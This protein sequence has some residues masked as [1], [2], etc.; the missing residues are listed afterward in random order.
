MNR[1]RR[2]RIEEAN[3][4]VTHALQILEEVRDEEQ[5]AL[6][7]TPESFETRREQ[8]DEAISVL[9]EQIS[10][11]QETENQLQYLVDGGE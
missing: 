8:M 9:E 1:R 4:L 6:D 2:D 10:G 7:G 11:L 3:G 5:E